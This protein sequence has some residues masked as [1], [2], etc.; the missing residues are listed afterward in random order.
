LLEKE[1]PH[2]V[3]PFI[4]C[5]ALA[6]LAS[7][8]LLAASFGDSSSPPSRAQLFGAT[9]FE[10]TGDGKYA[11]IGSDLSESIV[12]ITTAGMTVVAAA[13]L[14]EYFPLGCLDIVLDAAEQKLFAYSKTWRK[15]FVLDAADLRLIH[16]I[17][18]I[19]MIGMV[20]SRDGRSLLTWNGGGTISTPKCADCGTSCCRTMAPGFT[21]S[22]PR[23][24]IPIP[25]RPSA[26]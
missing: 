16:R 12:K 4:R 17:D 2:R 15:V 5:V 3:N 9:A 24:A 25:S 7:S 19:D 8:M 11:Y 10:L 22:S 1:R 6:L 23:G 14:S 26:R 21:P 13:D 20:R 18:D